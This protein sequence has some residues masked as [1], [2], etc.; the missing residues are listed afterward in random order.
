M[1]SN[2]APGG[3]GA[4]G[5]PSD[6]H[7]VLFDVGGVLVELSGVEVMLG[8]LG[9]S[10]T[11][12]EMWRRWLRSEPVR[13]FETGRIEAAEF[14]TRVTQEFDL[15]VDP[16]RFLESF[17]RW[18]TGLYPGTLE[19]LERIPSTYQRALLSNSNSLH[20]PRVLGE[21]QLGSVFDHHFVSH[22]TGRIKPDADAFEHVAATLGCAP[23]RVLFLDDN[24][25]NV[26]AARQVG[27]QSV[28]VQGA[29][30]AQRALTDFGIIQPA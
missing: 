5:A 23:A 22:L 12:E 14:A 4:S 24:S 9:Q 25:L 29:L 1:R 13:Q 3:S 15:P 19:M 11:T 27:M 8:W 16:Q 7:V 10:M 28:R 20:W 2:G 26:E 6:I 21:M 17:T 18:P 30:E